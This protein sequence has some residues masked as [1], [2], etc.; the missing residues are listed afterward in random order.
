MKKLL[1]PLI[2]ILFVAFFGSMIVSSSF[3]F[4][5]P[6]VLGLAS[7]QILLPPTSEGPG[8]ILPDSPLYFLD[9]LKQQVRLLFAVTPLQKAQVYNSVAGERIAEVR[10]ELAKG[11]VEA[12]IIALR[13]L[14]D[15][16]RNASK[17]LAQ[18]K[19]AGNNIGND[20]LLVNRTIVE[21]QKILDAA[22]QQATGELKA[23]IGVTQTTLSDAK[24]IAEDGLSQDELANAIRDDLVRDAARF[25]INTSDAATELKISLGLLQQQATLAAKAN[26]V[27]RQQAIQKAIL[28]KDKALEIAEKTKL[29]DEQQKDTFSQSLQSQAAIETEDVVRKAGEVAKTV[30]TSQQVLSGMITPASGK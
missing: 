14:Q 20:A 11:N 25:A 8:Y 17:S 3:A 10:F 16:T 2:F 13:G 24:G 1:I 7:T 18:A 4:S 29:D 21:H 28:Q 12:A 9:L 22:E 15:N 30:K 6:Q 26:L 23:D 27:M 5:R 19:F